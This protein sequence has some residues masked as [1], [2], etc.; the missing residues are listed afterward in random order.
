MSGVRVNVRKDGRVIAEADLPAGS[1]DPLLD[2]LESKKISMP[3]GCRSGSCG[4]CQVKVDTGAELLEGRGP[5]EEDSA[6]NFGL[7]PEMRLTCR[8]RLRTGAVG[9]LVLEIP[10]LK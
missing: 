1:D 10:E 5:M 3:F 2:L 9:L 7:A 6:A 8:A 4:S